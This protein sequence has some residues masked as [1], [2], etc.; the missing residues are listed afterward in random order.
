[1][2]LKLVL[3]A[4]ASALVAL[5]L[6]CAPAFQANAK[7]VDVKTLYKI[8][9]KNAETK[10]SKTASV[11]FSIIL[12]KA[13]TKV[14]PQAPFRCTVTPSK[15]AKADK[16]KLG[17]DDKKVAKDKKSVAVAVGVK[18]DTAGSHTVTLDCSFFVCTKDICARTTEK[19]VAKAT[20]K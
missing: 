18:S 5:A 9:T 6:V 17:H 15:G 4:T 2:K 1:M 11:G 14:H 20:V 16:S 8:E 7:P 10:K 19:V 3:S 13:G 12:T